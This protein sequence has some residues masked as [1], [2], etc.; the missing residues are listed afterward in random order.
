MQ[1]KMALVVSYVCARKKNNPVN[2]VEP[3]YIHSNIGKAH[4]L[5]LFL[6][7]ILVLFCKVIVLILV[8]W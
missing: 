4:C 7:W 3:I 8:L 6:A 1:C 2:F 5:Q